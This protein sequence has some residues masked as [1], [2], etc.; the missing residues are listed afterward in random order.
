VAF[1]SLCLSVGIVK[2]C[3]YVAVVGVTLPNEVERA[4]RVIDQ[5]C[6]DH[7]PVGLIGFR[8]KAETEVKEPEASYI[9][10][11][12]RYLTER[13]YP[14]C[15]LT[16]LASTSDTVVGRTFVSVLYPFAVN[17]ADR[18]EASRATA[19]GLDL[20]R[21]YSEDPA[22]INFPVDKPTFCV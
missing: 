12:E 21:V 3:I 15:I 22:G 17:N 16:C 19:I 1:P 13:G 10:E 5:A 9:V 4:K 14:G 2:F 20:L 11:V 8:E 6:K 7:N 18:K